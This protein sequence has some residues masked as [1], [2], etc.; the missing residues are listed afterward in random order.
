[1]RLS[2]TLRDGEETSEEL[3]ERPIPLLA[4]QEIAQ[5]SD[6]EIIGFHCHLPPFRFTR[7]DW[8]KH[9]LLHQRRNLP[10]PQVSA[11]P[12]IADIPLSSIQSKTFRLPH[13]YID[14]DLIQINWPGKPDNSVKIT[15]YRWRYPKY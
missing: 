13:E 7:M 5:L 11:L 1:H 8:R 6:E 3:A 9:P 2:Q 14:P 10:A 12:P 4:S 15:G